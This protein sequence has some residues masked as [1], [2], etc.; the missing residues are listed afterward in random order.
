MDGIALLLGQWFS[1][2][3]IGHIPGGRYYSLFATKTNGNQAA[4]GK[5]MGVSRTIYYSTSVLLL[6]LLQTASHLAWEMGAIG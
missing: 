5:Q 6:N 3:T 1:Y 2:Q 4:L